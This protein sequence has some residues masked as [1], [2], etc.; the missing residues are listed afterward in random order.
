MVHFIDDVT[1]LPWQSTI[2][3]WGS[4]VAF[5]LF[6]AMMATM[7]FRS[8]KRPVQNKIPTVFYC[9]FIAFLLALGIT[10]VAAIS[11]LVDV[12]LGWKLSLVAGIAVI[13]MGMSI[14]AMIVGCFT[15]MSLS[16]FFMWML[17]A[18]VS[19][20]SIIGLVELSLMAHR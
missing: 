14:I 10:L 20:G 4:S 19:F 18:A 11:F 2:L 12:E 5:A 3:T 6:F 16:R 9:V 13:L 7:F 8:K 15:N 17:F 1:L